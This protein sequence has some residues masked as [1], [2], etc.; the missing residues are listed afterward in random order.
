MVILL[1]CER[2]V[3]FVGKERKSFFAEIGVKFISEFH[4][5]KRSLGGR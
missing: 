4:E 3:T 5:G 2:M 1:K